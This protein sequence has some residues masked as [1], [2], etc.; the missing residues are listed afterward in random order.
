MYRAYIEGLEEGGGTAATFAI[1]SGNSTSGTSETF[2]F[3]AGMY[4]EYIGVAIARYVKD[5]GR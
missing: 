4:L 1:G 3:L 5:S 2:V